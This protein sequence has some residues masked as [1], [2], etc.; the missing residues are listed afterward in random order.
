MDQPS[1]SEYRDINA[2]AH[3]IFSILANPA[4]HR[5]IDGTGMLRAAI[6]DQ[7]IS[8]V[9]DMFYMSMVHW[10]RG[11]YVMTNEVVEF[12][13][14]RRIVWEPVSAIWDRAEFNLGNG[15]SAHQLWGWQLEPLDEDNTRVTEFFDCSRCPEELRTYIKDGEF[16]R[17]AMVNSLM[18]L[19][20]MATE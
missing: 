3:R 9:G 13:Q 7:V 2:P 5:E 6:E 17:L 1:V 20:K 14:D 4:L 19:E 15:K 8:R 11:N 16:W 12:E 18:N 10:D